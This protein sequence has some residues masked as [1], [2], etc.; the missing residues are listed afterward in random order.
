MRFL[1]DLGHSQL[2]SIELSGYEEQTSE[3]AEPLPWR[4]ISLDWLALILR[5]L[6]E[7]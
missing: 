1:C 7:L 3:V 6:G 5:F 2:G 4:C